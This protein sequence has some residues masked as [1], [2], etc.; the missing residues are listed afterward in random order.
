MHCPIV[1]P[2]QTNWTPRGSSKSTRRPYH[3]HMP[4]SPPK[5]LTIALSGLS[6]TG[7]SSIASQLPSIFPP[8]LYA[9]TLLHVDDFYKPQAELP[10]RDGLLDWDC[11]ASLDWPHLEAAV[12]KWRDGEPVDEGQVNP[13]PGCVGGAGGGGIT[14]ALAEELR[15]EVREKTMTSTESKGG[16]TAQRILVLDGFLLFTPSVPRSFVSLLD[17]KILLRAPYE[18][19]KRRREARSGYTTM[20]GWWEDPPG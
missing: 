8:P 1:Q 4:P 7:K 16:T 13:Q 14:Q 10:L 17:V 15:R 9:L 2:K 6:S 19:A 12:R 20:E 11:T 18:E 5:P 3:L